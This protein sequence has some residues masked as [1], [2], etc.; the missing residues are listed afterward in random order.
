MSKKQVVPGILMRRRIWDD[1]SNIYVSKPENYEYRRVY[2][3]E[4]AIA[5]N[6]PNFY[7]TNHWQFVSFD[8]EFVL[9]LYKKLS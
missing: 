7:H 1:S 8:V 3:M 4:T 9:D 5:M 2:D 6:E